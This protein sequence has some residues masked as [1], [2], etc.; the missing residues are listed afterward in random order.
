MTS[1]YNLA[2]E[3]A[4][5]LA[6]LE[7]LNLDDATVADTIEASGLVDDIA[8]KAQ[9]CEMVARN[10]DALLPAIDVEIERLKALKKSHQAKAAGIREYL[11]TQIE[12]V[13]LTKIQCP[14][15]SI[16][17][18]KN[19]PAVEILDAALIP[20]EYMRTPEPLPPP[21]PVP[22]KKAIAAALKNEIE[23]QGVRLVHS[24]RLSIK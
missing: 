1:L 10:F 22:D 2:G 4:E 24:T 18:V 15:F 23:I 13:N 3:Y 11:K 19:N 6:K 16:S 7:G 9:G 8:T 5:L 17:I 12:G 14:L 21:D 20:A